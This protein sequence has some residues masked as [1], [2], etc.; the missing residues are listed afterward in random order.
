MTQQ[1]I[2]ETVH[3]PLL[4]YTQVHRCIESRFST[5]P[6]WGKY[7]KAEREARIAARAKAD[8]EVLSEYWSAEEATGHAV[9]E[10][11]KARQRAVMAMQGSLSVL[12]HVPAYGA[13]Q[14]VRT[15]VPAPVP[16]AAPAP[17]PA[18]RAR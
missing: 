7:G 14:V 8:E 2:T 1:M 10:A 3:R 15:A 18:R 5:A 11:E 13:P 6:A 17:A 9:P 12:A 16:P 4:G